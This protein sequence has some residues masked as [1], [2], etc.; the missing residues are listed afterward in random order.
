M[1]DYAKKLGAENTHF[2]VPD[3]YHDDESLYH[4]GGYAK[5]CNCGNAE[6][7]RYAI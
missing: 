1:N 4:G 2:T 6:P 7:V 5:I 3:G